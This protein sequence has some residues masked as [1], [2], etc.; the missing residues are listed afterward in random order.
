MMLN[1]SDI[2]LQHNVGCSL[3]LKYYLRILSRQFAKPLSQ[4]FTYLEQMNIWKF[5]C[6]LYIVV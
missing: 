1:E 4:F 2:L 6:L 3:M 5:L